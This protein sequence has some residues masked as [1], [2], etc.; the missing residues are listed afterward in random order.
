MNDRAVSE[1]FLARAFEF[2]RQDAE[3]KAPWQH[4]LE[5]K[6]WGKVLPDFSLEQKA[7]VLTAYGKGWQAAG[8]DL[9]P[10]H[11]LPE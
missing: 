2:G 11:P 8:K 1:E 10:G 3:T 4:S 7:V 6:L 9:P 5:E